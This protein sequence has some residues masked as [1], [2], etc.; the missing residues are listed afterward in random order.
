MRLTFLGTGSAMPTGERF[1]TG[2]LLETVD[3]TL[4]I[5]CGSGALHGLARTQT[6]YEG[7]DTV[8]LT[9]HHLDHVSDLMPLMK[10]RWLAGETELTVLG[11]DGTESL[12][13][14]LLD[15]HEY[16]QDR[17][18]LT[19]RDIEPTPQSAPHEI[20]GFEVAAMETRH[21]MY[22][23]AYRFE[24]PDEAGPITFSAD[25]E[26][27]TDLVEFADGSAVFVHDC[28]FPDEVDV[29]NH[30]TPE[31]LGQTLDEADAALGRVYLTHLYPHTDGK[32]EEM[33]ASIGTYYDG[34]VRI[35]RDELSIDVSE[36]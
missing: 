27:F 5:D 26:A 10:A 31:K 29:S 25:S 23:L 17:L 18:D 35:A 19:V 16:M 13:A 22:C 2:L 28:S 12:V 15:A 11:P 8:L 20:A 33:L 32:H 14:D 4:M 7:V 34:D 3:E 9:H 30:P 21:S 6:G 24:S 36:N 1:Q